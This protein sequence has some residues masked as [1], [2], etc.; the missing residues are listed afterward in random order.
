MNVLYSY[1]SQNILNSP[2]KAMTLYPLKTLSLLAALFEFG[3]RS[4]K[5]CP[6]P[7]I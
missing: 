4:S 1:Y 7:K 5:S 3:T 6:W 2:G